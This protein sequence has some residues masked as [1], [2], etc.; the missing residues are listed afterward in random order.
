MFH[1][2][3]WCS[4]VIMMLKPSGLASPQDLLRGTVLQWF[5]CGFA[6]WAF[7]GACKLVGKIPAIRP[8]PRIRAYYN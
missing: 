5:K 1:D 3:E 7:T 4:T 6:C 8:S 2:A